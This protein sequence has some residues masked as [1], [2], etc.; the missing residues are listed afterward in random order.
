LST[1]ALT[2]VPGRPGSS[3]ALILKAGIAESGGELIEV[4]TGVVL[5]PLDAYEPVEW[6]EDSEPLGT[7][8][9]AKVRELFHALSRFPMLKLREL[10]HRRARL[11]RLSASF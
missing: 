2:A 3:M 10:P 6:Q 9:P 5:E 11:R 4:Q 8:S 7:P 1:S